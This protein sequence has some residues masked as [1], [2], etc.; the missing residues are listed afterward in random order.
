LAPSRDQGANDDDDDDDDDED[1]HVQ[2]THTH[3]QTFLQDWDILNSLELC[4]LDHHH[5]SPDVLVEL[6][7][8]ARL[9]F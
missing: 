3:T 4:V 1:G 8:Y 9:F 2:T 7:I 5:G 6:F